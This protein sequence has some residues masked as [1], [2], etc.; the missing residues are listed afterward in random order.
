VTGLSHL[1]LAVADVT[2]C[3]RWW[4]E[5]LGLDVLYEDG[6]SVV[7]LRH[8]SGRFV[9][10]LSTRSSGSARTADRLDHVA[11]AVPDRTTL[12]TWVEHLDEVGIEH[13]GVVHELGNH[14]LQLVDP[15]GTRVELVA[16]PDRR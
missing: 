13:P 11:F 12:D 10:V 7:A 9:I 4:T 5:V 3:R 6:D 2:A 14:S 16:P 15:D 8:R 1:Q